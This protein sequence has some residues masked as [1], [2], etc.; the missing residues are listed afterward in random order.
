M[1]PA[2][3]NDTTVVKPIRERL[4]WFAIMA[5]AS[6]VRFHGLDRES[7]WFDEAATDRTTAG[8]LGAVFT[9]NAFDST[10]PLYFVGVW[11]VR[12]LFGSGDSAVRAWGAACSLAGVALAGGF[13]RAAAGRAAGVAA[14]GLMAVAPLDVYFAQEARMYSQTAALATGS[15]WALW[16]WMR[17]A[18]ET[19]SATGRRSRRRAA[20]VYVAATAAMLLS[21]YAA[22]AVAIAQGVAVMAAATRRRDAPMAAGYAMMTC[23]VAAGFAPWL[24]YVSIARGKFGLD[25]QNAAWITFPAWHQYVDYLFLEFFS[26]R[27]WFV[28]ASR[29]HAAGVLA[30]ISLAAAA[31]AAWSRPAAG[32][33]LWMVFAPVA[34]AFALGHVKQ[35]IYLR[36]NFSLFLLPMFCVGVSVSVF[37]RRLFSRR[38]AAAFVGVVAAFMAW[39]TFSQ[40]RAALKDDW[41]GFAAL[42]RADPPAAAVFHP[43]F[44][45]IAAARYLGHGF[46][47]L[48]YGDFEAEKASLAGRRVWLVTDRHRDNSHDPQ[49]DSVV[50]AILGSGAAEPGYIDLGARLR[51]MVV[52]R[53]EPTTAD[54]ARF[55]RWTEPVATAPWIDGFGDPRRFHAAETGPDLRVFRWSKGSAWVTLHGVVEG[56]TLTMG[57]DYPAAPPDWSPGLILTLRRESPTSATTADQSGAFLEGPAKPTGPFEMEAAAPPGDGPLSLGWTSNPV[58]PAAAGISSDTR[59]L[60]VRVRFIATRQRP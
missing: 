55:D 35:P 44:Q 48:T 40:S 59:D 26:G 15:T 36:Q 9:N 42:H 34:A 58:N 4:A 13:A 18:G 21:H 51:R 5:F 20:A 38:I 49:Q 25:G 29:A 7:F 22:L 8:G 14:L 12:N 41:R 33:A 54:A 2:P 17:R 11:V 27:N 52:G 46:R 50:R 53:T 37:D 10:P 3:M 19:P 31:R 39:G 32:L 45:G 24:A 23:A 56:T 16:A 28:Y 60:G 6:F 57:L 1:T 47:P 30:L 43:A